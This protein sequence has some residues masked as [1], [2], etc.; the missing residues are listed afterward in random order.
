MCRWGVHTCPKGYTHRSIVHQSACPRPIRGLMTG[1]HV[2]L[3]EDVFD[4]DPGGAGRDHELLR[5]LSIASSPSDQAGNLQLTLGEEPTRS[6]EPGDRAGR[7]LL[8]G[9]ICL[10]PQHVEWTAFTLRPRPLESSL[11]E[12]GADPSQVALILF[13]ST[14]WQEGA[15]GE[16]QRVSGAEEACGGPA[17]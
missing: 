1:L 6:P 14:G 16:A 10:V 7:R 15:G 13:S 2:E 17:V 11:A 3:A 5:D 4:V 8:R 9:R 12:M